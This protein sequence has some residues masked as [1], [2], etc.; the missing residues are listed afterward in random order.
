MGCDPQITGA[1]HTGLGAGGGTQDAII[2]VRPDLPAPGDVVTFDSG[3]LGNGDRTWD[4]GDGGTGTGTIVGHTF[5]AEGVFTVK[6]TFDDGSGSLV[7]RTL[8]VR[9]DDPSTEPQVAQQ[10][11]LRRSN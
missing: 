10:P 11:Q 1:K 3:Q 7:D 6:V 2:T 4:F 9:V 8:D 5:A